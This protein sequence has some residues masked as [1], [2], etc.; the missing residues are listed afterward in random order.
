MLLTLAGYFYKEV[1]EG[2]LK[3]SLSTP[4]S[5]KTY[6]LGFLLSTF[7]VS[8]AVTVIYI[9]INRVRGA[10]FLGNPLE[11]LLVILLQSLLTTCVV[12]A[13]IA[14][15]KKEAAA[16]ALMSALFIIPSVFGGVFFYSEAIGFKLIKALMNN[17]PNVLILNAYKNLSITGSLKG[18]QGELLAMSI[19]SIILLAISLIKIELKWEV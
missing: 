7:I 9:I 8:F 4:T 5:K 18:I 16:N 13:V 1:K 17:V 15:I 14:F 6:F 12:G 11:L 10:A 3:R 2:I 19:L